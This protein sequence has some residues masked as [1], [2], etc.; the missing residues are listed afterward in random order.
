MYDK[1]SNGRPRFPSV[2]ILGFVGRAKFDKLPDLLRRLTTV[3]LEVGG[4]EGFL[5]GD[6]RGSCRG[7]RAGFLSG[8][9]RVRGLVGFLSGGSRGSCQANGGDCVGKVEGYDSIEVDS[10]RGGNR[11]LGW[12][13]CQ[14]FGTGDDGTGGG[15]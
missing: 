6:S 15:E 9:S 8:D 5:S 2:A 10:D 4:L 11:C 7:T 13:G 1:T 12:S 3:E 14:P